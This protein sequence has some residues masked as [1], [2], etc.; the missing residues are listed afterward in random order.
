MAV[1]G[2]VFVKQTT[3]LRHE[4]RHFFSGAREDFAI[5]GFGYFKHFTSNRIG[6]AE[7]LSQ[8]ED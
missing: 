2:I 1:A 7:D 3:I 6:N 4:I 8:D 5:V